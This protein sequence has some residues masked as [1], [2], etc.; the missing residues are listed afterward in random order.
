MSCAR[1][2]LFTKVTRDPAEIVTVRGDTL[3][4]VIVIVAVPGVGL[5]EGEGEGDG[6][7]DGEGE[8]GVEFPPPQPIAR[9][10][11]TATAQHSER[12]HPGSTCMAPTRRLEELS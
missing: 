6:A 4:A 2:S 11:T 1:V 3:F 5:G 10:A 7:G 12:T 8:A 9:T